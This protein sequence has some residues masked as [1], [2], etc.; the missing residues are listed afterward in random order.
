VLGS[1]LFTS[2]GRDDELRASDADRDQAVTRLRDH[3]VAGRLDLEEFTDRV[4]Q[5][6]RS[7]TL[8]QL[9]LL[10]RDLPSTPRLQLRRR[11]PS[12][13]TRQP[14]SPNPLIWRSF[15]VHLYAYVVTCVGVVVSERAQFVYPIVQD[16]LPN[17]VVLPMVAWGVGVTWHGLAVSWQRLRARPNG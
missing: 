16:T 3:H 17:W 2:R 6:L 11:R 13:P 1:G 4:H 14:V 9:D 15:P 5:A 12:P 8:G 10:F 7:R